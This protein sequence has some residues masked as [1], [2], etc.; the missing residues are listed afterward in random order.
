MTLSAAAEIPVADPATVIADPRI[1]LAARVIAA[2][3]R[4]HYAAADKVMA[5]AHKGKL[6]A[7]RLMRAAY[8]RIL[9]RMNKIGWAPP[10]SRVSLS[11]LEKL[12]VVVRH[13][14]FG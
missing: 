5:R 3:A 7:P 10:R 14:L 4:V 9:A 1:D 2:E 6:R 13:G 11:K 8:G 12:W